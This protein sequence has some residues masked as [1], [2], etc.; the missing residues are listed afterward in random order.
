MRS[1][2]RLLAVRV[3]LTVEPYKQQQ[4]YNK[5]NIFPIALYI[6]HSRAESVC[7]VYT[8]IFLSFTKT[9]KKNKKIL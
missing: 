4:H 7:T 3:M 6:F 9:R 5:N 2:P 1:H 8:R